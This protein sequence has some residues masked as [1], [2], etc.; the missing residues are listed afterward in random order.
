MAFDLSTLSTYTNGYGQELVAKLVAKGQTS[1]VVNIHPDVKSAVSIPTHS[2]TLYLTAGSCG[3][4][5]SGSTVIGTMVLSVDPISYLEALCVQTAQQY[6][7]QW[8]TKAGTNGDDVNFAEKFMDEKLKQVALANE[9]L[10]WKGS[11]ANGTGNNARTDGYLAQLINT[12][13]SA[14]T[15][16]TTGFT[17]ISSS[18]VIALFDSMRTIA[19]S[20]IKQADDLVLF[21]GLDSFDT[22]IQALRTANNFFYDVTGANTAYRIR[23]PG[24]NVT[25]IG[26]VGLDGT[27]PITNKATAVLSPASNF[28]LG[29]DLFDESNRADLWYSQDFRE[30]RCA[31]MYKLGYKIMFPEFVVIHKS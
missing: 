26:T 18:N 30:I 24:S 5:P 29:T 31:I 19:P 22:Y 21:C 20:A 17:G 16:N 10:A 8:E 2:T 1:E 9:N 25:V 27:N 23:I 15:V 11:K 28:Y 14:S 3:W 12:S 7:L 6:Q 13:A 4:N